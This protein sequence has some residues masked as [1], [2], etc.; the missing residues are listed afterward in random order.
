LY[1]AIASKIVVIETI[2]IESDR[3]MRAIK[4]QIKPIERSHSERL[5]KNL[6]AIMIVLI[7]QTII[8]PVAFLEFHMH[9]THPI[10]D[11]KQD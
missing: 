7:M 6:S 4:K 10:P 8:I 1:L 11:P 2:Q 3:I 5:K 9:S